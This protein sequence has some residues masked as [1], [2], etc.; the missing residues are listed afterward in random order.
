MTQKSRYLLEA[1]KRPKRPRCGRGKKTLEV[2]ERAAK[3][4][5]Q[6]QSPVQIRLKTFSELRSRAAIRVVVV[7]LT[8]GFKVERACAPLF[9]KGDCRS[10]K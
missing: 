10:Q 3:S 8:I 2:G 6:K 9:L 7:A 5:L 1:R 4:A